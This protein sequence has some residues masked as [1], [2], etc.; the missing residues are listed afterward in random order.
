MEENTEKNT[1]SINNEHSS[2]DVATN[3]TLSESIRMNLYKNL[4]FMKKMFN[5]SGY[6]FEQFLDQVD[7]LKVLDRSISS[8]KKFVRATADKIFAIIDWNKDSRVS[9]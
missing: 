4:E 5:T 3:N 6:T 8:N 2:S 7:F 9:V 1:L